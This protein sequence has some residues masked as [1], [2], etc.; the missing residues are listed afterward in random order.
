ML[1]SVLNGITEALNNE[2]TTNDASS[3][4]AHEVSYPPRIK[5][6]PL[7][8]SSWQ[9]FKMLS[10]LVGEKCL[11]TLDFPYLL[12]RAIVLPLSIKNAYLASNFCIQTKTSEIT[13]PGLKGK[14]IIKTTFGNGR[15]KP[16][17]LAGMGE[18]AIKL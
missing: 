11:G 12:S 8:T 15:C 2:T 4:A 6:L 14:K 16:R 3:A 5:C 1:K 9:H 18:L 13:T 7:F 10:K 17:V